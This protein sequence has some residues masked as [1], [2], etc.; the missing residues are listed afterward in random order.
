LQL[1]N[2][3]FYRR[4]HS[5]DSL[6]HA[7]T[8]L[9]LDRIRS[10]LT[11]INMGRLRDKP[12]ELQREALTRAFFCEHLAGQQDTVTAESGFTVGLLS[13]LDAWLDRPMQSIVDQLPLSAEMKAALTRREGRLGDLLRVAVGF[14]HSQWEALPELLLQSG[15]VRQWQEAYSQSVTRAD[16]LLD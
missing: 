8:L 15:D 7:V 3:A 1:V 5:V 2:S 11:L 4:A 14:S 6:H 9:G 10:W 16:E 13:V 12:G